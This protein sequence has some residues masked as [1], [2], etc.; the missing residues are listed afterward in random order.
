M[1]EDQCGEFAYDVRSMLSIRRALTPIT[2]RP[3]DVRPLCVTLLCLANALSTAATSRATA[4]S[5]MTPSRTCADAA[6]ARRPRR[7]TSPTRRSSTPLPISAAPPPARPRPAATL[8]P[9]PTAPSRSASDRYCRGL[10]GSGTASSVVHDGAPTA[11]ASP[12]YLFPR[13]P[14]C[15]PSRI[16][17]VGSVHHFGDSLSLCPQLPLRQSSWRSGR[18]RA[19][20]L[21]RVDRLHLLSSLVS[22]PSG[23]QLSCWTTSSSCVW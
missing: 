6:R 20:L 14:P 7:R 10:E 15:G 11:D 4:T 12:A 23:G 21:S 9:I 3:Q 8:S 2:V 1:D 13:V 18:R 22:W 19:T 5:T 17:L 16:V